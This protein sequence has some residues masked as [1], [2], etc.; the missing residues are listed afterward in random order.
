MLESVSVARSSQKQFSLFH[1]DI[2]HVYAYFSSRFATISF[3]RL[4]AMVEKFEM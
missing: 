4:V 3:G 2:I 1:R